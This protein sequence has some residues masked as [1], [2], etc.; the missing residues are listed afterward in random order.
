MR[1]ASVCALVAL[2]AVLLIHGGS[3]AGEPVGRVAV[4]CGRG[5]QAEL[6]ERL[7]SA[8]RESFTCATSVS[9]LDAGVPGTDAGM[10]PL[11]RAT[12]K[13]GD[14]LVLVVLDEP[15]AVCSNA[16]D[17]SSEGYAVVN[18]AGYRPRGPRSPGTD[19]VTVQRSERE[20]LRMV[21]ALVGMKTCPLPLC[22]LSESATLEELDA[23]G[24]NLCPHCRYVS[25]PLIRK[26]G[27]A[28][29][30]RRLKV[31]EQPAPAEGD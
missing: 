7:A 23:K 13:A 15:S 24:M 18:L 21:G 8:V 12:R 25:E 1:K 16:L 22:A 5:V 6:G 28:V 2:G 4:M 14:V 31:K 19:E 30:P 29:E 20:A 17:V 26:A 27:I 3:R 9:L 11:I 10:T